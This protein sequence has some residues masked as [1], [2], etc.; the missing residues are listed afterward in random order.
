MHIHA[1]EPTACAD[2]QDTESWVSSLT[3]E[4]RQVQAEPVLVKPE[5]S[6]DADSCVVWQGDVSFPGVGCV[7][8][9]GF[10]A[11]SEELAPVYRGLG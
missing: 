1:Q 4:P 9:F 3:T 6:C 5:V 11:E 7:E 2:S 8:V 10:E